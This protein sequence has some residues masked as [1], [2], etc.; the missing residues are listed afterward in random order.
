M[1]ESLQNSVCFPCSWEYFSSCTTK[2]INFLQKPI[3]PPLVLMIVVS[4][5]SSYSTLTF[6]LSLMSFSL[7]LY[8]VGVIW[9]LII[10]IW[11]GKKYAQWMYDQTGGNVDA[12]PS[13]RLSVILGC[14]ALCVAFVCASQIGSSAAAKQWEDEWNSP[15]SYSE[16]WASDDFLPSENYLTSA[17]QIDSTADTKF[18]QPAW[19]VLVPAQ[20]PWYGVWADPFGGLRTFEQDF[21]FAT[22]TLQSLE[23]GTQQI[24][25]V[26][27]RDNSIRMVYTY[28]PKGTEMMSAYDSDGNYQT[29]YCRPDSPSQQ[30]LPEEMWGLYMPIS[31]NLYVGPDDGFLVDAYRFGDYL[32]NNL[33]Q[34]NDGNYTFDQPAFTEIRTL[35]IR[36][37][38]KSGSPIIS[39][40]DESGNVYAEFQ[41][42]Q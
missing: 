13:S 30:F 22:E 10:S 41:K 36:Y 3:F 16:Q 18:I 20:T 38:N 8:I 33:V 32:Y 29:F 9:G 12:I 25:M 14:A 11:N 31:G 40:L 34:N 42:L 24:T 35:T 17:P 6:N 21:S 39:V 27:S 15:V 26:D 37:E 5:I 4:G 19:G 2:V 23:D 7:F 1:Q 28:Q